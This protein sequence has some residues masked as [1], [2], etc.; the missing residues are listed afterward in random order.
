MYEFKY[1]SVLALATVEGDDQQ[2]LDF[3]F[4]KTK[5]VRREQNKEGTTNPVSLKSIDS[6]KLEGQ[7]DGSPGKGSWR[8][9]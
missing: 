5:S 8:Q 6:T 7:G 9:A 4:F 1:H 2:I 3:F